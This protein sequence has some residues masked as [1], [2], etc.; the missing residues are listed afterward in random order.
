MNAAPRLRRRE[1][2]P[3]Q[4]LLRTRP[5]ISLKIFLFAATTIAVWLQISFFWKATGGDTFLDLRYFEEI[6]SS[7]NLTLDSIAKTWSSPKTRSSLY[8]WCRTE[9]SSLLPGLMYIKIDKA[10]SSTLAGINIR[11]AHKVG[12][13]SQVEGGVCSHSK[14]HFR[15][16]TRL[17]Q[18][19]LL[20][21]SSAN[22]R[23]YQHQQLQPRPLLWTFLRDPAQRA[24]SHYFHFFVSR[25][26]Y[27]VHQYH[28]LKSFLESMKNFQLQYVMIPPHPLGASTNL[29]AILMQVASHPSSVS[30]AF[31]DDV[32]LQHYNFIGLVER[33]DESLAVMKLLWKLD[34]GDLM[35]IS[36]KES[37]NYDDGR[38]Q[39]KCIRIVRS[40]DYDGDSKAQRVLQRIQEFL[41]TEFLHD[42][43]DYALY[44]AV[45]KSLD[46]TIAVLG[47]DRVEQ[48]VRDLQRL[49]EL[50]EAKCQ[51]ATVFP[52]SKNGTRQME[53]SARNCYWFDS[54]CGY[55]CVDQL[56]E[57]HPKN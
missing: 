31:L 34:V 36:A 40:S 49:R 1:A 42:N 19:E 39:N 50:V 14:E 51:D 22:P 52:C 43:L 37:G 7:R 12:A 57:S 2:L 47:T 26:G 48:T 21:E 8:P 18:V 33:F 5:R 15:A 17:S 20:Q 9:G 32:V 25:H 44:Q 41:G 54:G 46:K 11:L 6:A 38:Y 24:M 28:L 45:N 4:A 56:L 35:V 27:G 55:P 23:Q 53:E 3:C 16:W 30:L 29:D 10:S 13:K